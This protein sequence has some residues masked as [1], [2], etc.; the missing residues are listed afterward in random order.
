M[1]KNNSSQH[2]EQI[3]EF[4]EKENLKDIDNDKT[5]KVLFFETEFNNNSI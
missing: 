1:E 5:D 3:E 4:F 2:S